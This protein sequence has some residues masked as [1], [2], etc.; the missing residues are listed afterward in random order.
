[1]KLSILVGERFKEQPA[2]AVLASHAIMIRGGY[3]RQVTQG[4]Y[5]L[6]PPAKRIAHKI[7]KILREEMDA[8]DSQEIMF[9][10]VLP[11]ELWEESG[12]YASVGSEL[13]RFK[14]RNNHDM[15]L[16][17]TH[18][19]AAVHLCINDL[20]SHSQLPF[21]IYQIQTKFRDEPRSRGGLIRVREFTMKDG[22]SFHVSQED[23]QLYYDRC[24]D[25]YVRIYKRAGLPQV[26]AVKSDTGMMGGSVAHEFML[27]CDAGEDSIVTC[28]QCDYRANM[29]VAEGILPKPDITG[30]EADSPTGSIPPIE[31]IY[32]PDIRTID[33]LSV[34][35]KQPTSRLMKAV[36]FES[37]D[38]E[39]PMIF[40][41]RGDLD[42]N[43]AKVKRYLKCNIVPASENALE[44]GTV[45]GFMGP[46][47][48]DPKHFDLFFDNSLKDLPSLV[49][50]ANKL[51]YH[52]KNFNFN[53]DYPD[54]IFDDFSKITDGSTCKHCGGTLSISRGIEVGNIFQLGTK[55]S[56]SMGMKFTDSDGSVKHPIMGCYGIGV[57]RLMASAIEAYHDDNGPI[58]P[59]TIAPWKVHIC[60]LRF[61]DE[62]V[63]STALS[64]YQ[65]LTARRIDT[66]IDDRN[67][68]AG[69]Q[70][71][72]AD[73]L[74]VPV[75]IV[76][77]P[78]NLKENAVELVTRDKQFK[79]MVPLNEIHS[80]VDQLIADLEAAIEKEL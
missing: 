79:K 21:S 54:A 69:V 13:V 30:A 56:V 34:L 17:M 47:G 6:L 52:I 71:A 51:N 44:V 29:E 11:R 7:E 4:I 64:L 41:I 61:D 27:L 59:I 22:Y 62:R 76:V 75:R 14:D 66:V 38:R 39:K 25:A 28:S 15:V 18:E 63:K 12:R 36:A 31:E 16:G 70:F 3:I 45:P 77:S 20:K 10:V 5:S 23:L 60:G 74:G 33:D 35:L 32:T 8:I 55:Y 48:L 37:I 72:D 2:E 1:M 58:W 57:G 78:R 24:Y 50:G 49:T 9:P 67:E 46:V 53:R 40:F 42:I 68:T 65:E 73:L 26:V 19:E 43:E 80:T